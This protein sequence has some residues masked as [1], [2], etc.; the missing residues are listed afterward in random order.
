MHDAVHLRAENASS[1]YNCRWSSPKVFQCA[2]HVS[3]RVGEMQLGP[4]LPLPYVAVAIQRRREGRLRLLFATL[5]RD[6]PVI[7]LHR[8]RARQTADAP[9]CVGGRYPI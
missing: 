1:F 8:N 9:C 4:H 7:D 2:T 5:R 6:V 3:S